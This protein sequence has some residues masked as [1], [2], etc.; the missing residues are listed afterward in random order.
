MNAILLILVIAG[1]TLQQIMKKA[2]NNKVRGGVFSFSAGSSLMALLFFA[3]TAKG[4]LTFSS[5]YI[6]YSVL[7]ALT[8]SMATVFSFFAIIEGPLALTS[9]VISY[10][11]L[12]PTGYGLLVLGEPVGV[13]L[14][15]GIV[16]LMISL[17]LINIEKKGEQKKI[18][19]KWA[20]YALLAFVGNGGCSLVQKVQQVDCNKQFKSEFM[21]L[22]YGMSVVILLIC[23]LFLEK[24]DTWK[25]LKTGLVYWAGNGLFNGMV[26]FLVLVLSGV[27]AASVMFPLISAGGIVAAFLVSL[28]IYREKLSTA[29]I[30]GLAFGIIS[31]VFLNL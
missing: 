14:I 15:I 18:T 29:Q 7:F 8:F 11:L 26:N 19:F 5:E 25:N 22:A 30:I 20:I 1:V 12:I 2:Y 4:N 21:L 24:K 31:V 6:I 3:A 16:F 23:A 9:L 27:M 17:L 13:N 28:F 10:S